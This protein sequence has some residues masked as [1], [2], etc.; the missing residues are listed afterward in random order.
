MKF[1]KTSMRIWITLTSVVGFF[2]GWAIL[3]HSPKPQPYTASSSSALNLAPVPKLS[4]MIGDDD[5]A[6]GGPMI[7]MSSPRN[8][9]P[10]LR[11]SGS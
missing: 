11:T 6:R 7:V 8:S 10:R 5:V 2:A 9:M 1:L 4:D 3:A